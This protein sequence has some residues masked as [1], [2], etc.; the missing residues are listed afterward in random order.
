MSQTV[1]NE[2]S[3]Q[4][5]NGQLA[6]LGLV[7]RISRIADEVIPYGLL[8][9]L[10]ASVD[11]TCKLPAAA[12]DITTVTKALGVSLVDLNK[13]T[14]AGIVQYAAQDPVGIV[15]KGR[16]WVTVEEAVTPTS[17]VYVRFVAGSGGSQLGSFRASADTASAALLAGAKYRSTT[18]GGAKLAL[19]ELDL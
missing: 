17:P 14:L 4:A 11:T 6:D 13:E 5:K 9:V 2:Y 18:T 10:G 15:R 3:D 7:E 19:L 1:Y 8:V 12:A 16:I